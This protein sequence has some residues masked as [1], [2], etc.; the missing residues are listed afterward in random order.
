MDS[1]QRSGTKGAAMGKRIKRSADQAFYEAVEQFITRFGE[2]LSGS[3]VLDSLRTGLMDDYLEQSILFWKSVEQ[4]VYY[5][6]D[7]NSSIKSIRKV[8]KEMVDFSK[9]SIDQTIVEA[10]DQRISLNKQIVTRLKALKFIYTDALD[11]INSYQLQISCD[12]EFIRK[13]IY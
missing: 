6:Y 10:I 7:L 4:L 12:N 13:Q 3:S 1:N 2:N 8:S 9:P 11:K 5:H